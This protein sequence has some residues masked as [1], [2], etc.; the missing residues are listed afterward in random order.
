[1]KCKNNFIMNINHEELIDEINNLFIGDFEHNI[2]KEGK[3]SKFAPIYAFTTENI[4]G[5]I[6]KVCPKGSSVLTVSGSG[7]HILNSFLCGAREFFSFD[8][9]I[10][11]ALFIDLKLAA[12]RRFSYKEFLDFFM[13]ED[14]NSTKNNLYTFNFDMYKDLKRDLHTIT[15]L[16]FDRVYE[17]NK[18]DGCKVRESS[19]F[20]NK[21]DNNKVKM[22]SN[23]YL[24]SEN[25]YREVQKNHFIKNIE[26]IDCSVQE[27]NIKLSPN[28]KFDVILLSNVSDY[29]KTM[30]N[31]QNNYLEQF[32]EF[33]I[34]PL[35]ERLN[36]NGIISAAYIYDVIINASR[37]FRSDIDNPEFRERVFNS[38]GMMYQE[39]YFNSVIPNKKDAVLLLNKQ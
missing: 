23:L 10:L 13:R 16:F 38:I 29:A 18:Y 27:L 35:K 8:V 20:N 7:D 33:I 24:Q 5:Y 39:L 11:S 2:T 25:L 3:F 17:L 32:A 37:Q 6:S 1:M 14:L 36:G 22:L 31:Y 12:L 21:F 15:K 26:W 19:L 30:Y 9:N 28:K 34:K 4:G